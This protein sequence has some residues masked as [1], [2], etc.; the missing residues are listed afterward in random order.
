[1]IKYTNPTITLTIEGID[2]SSYTAAV[3]LAQKDRKMTISSD[4]FT[5]TKVGD[6]TKIELTLTQQQSAFFD[7]HEPLSV[8]VNWQ[9][10]DGPRGATRIGTLEVL[11]N[12]CDVA[13]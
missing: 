1:M 2:I 5:M 6:D 4:D 11:E 7:H 12:L 9:P 3:T 13:W 8:Q 10:L